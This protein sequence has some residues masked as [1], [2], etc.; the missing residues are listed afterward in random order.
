MFAL[1][2]GKPLCV[3]GQIYVLILI[4]RA[5]LS[6]FPLSPES[7]FAAVWR[8]VFAVTEPLLA[9]LRRIIPP[10]GMLDLSFLV[11]FFVFELVI[12]RLLCL[13]SFTI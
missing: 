3:I 12:V 6:W 9:P 7:P 8:F 4:A 10:V 13:I 1:N 5:I 11:A 2:F